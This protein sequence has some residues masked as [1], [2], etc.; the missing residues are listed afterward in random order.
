MILY[1]DT[2][3]VVTLLTNEPDSG[4]VAKWLETHLS[5]TLAVSE[6][7]TTEVSSALSIKVRSRQIS[8]EVRAAALVDYKRMVADTLETLPIA[9]SH[10]RAA[11]GFIERGQSGLRAGDALHVAIAAAHGAAIVSRDRLMTVAASEL[12]FGAHLV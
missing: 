11:T 3:V 5:E 1:L 6:W 12:G 10:F 7:V 8:S 2:S 9:E 4:H